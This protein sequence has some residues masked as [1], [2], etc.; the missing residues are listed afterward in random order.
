VS[1]YVAAP[2]AGA[3]KPAADL[4]VAIG[5]VDIPEQQ[6][7]TEF[8]H[9]FP[10]DGNFAVFGASGFGKSTVLMNMALALAAKNTPEDVHFYALD[11]GNSALVQLK[12]LPHTGDYMTYDQEEK[13]GKFS[14]LMLDELSERKRLF[15]KESAIN[16]KMYNEVA[17]EKLPAVFIVVDGFDIVKEIPGELEDFFTRLTR[18]GV[19]VGIYT[20]I[21]VTAVT[22]VRY[23]IQ[24]NI[25]NKISL[26]LFEQ[27]DIASIVGRSKYTLPETKG[28]AFVKMADVNVMQCYLPIAFES[29]VAYAR[30][31]GGLIRALSETYPSKY[32]AGIPM[33]PEYVSIDD[34]KR[35]KGAPLMLVPIGL[36]KDEV[37]PQHL[38]LAFDRHL[39]VGR[40]RSGKSNVLKIILAGLQGADVDVFVAD[41]SAQDMQDAATAANAVYSSGQEDVEQLIEALNTFV[42]TRESAYQAQSGGVRQKEFFASLDPGV[43][44]IDDG[45]YFS[46]LTNAGSHEVAETLRRF[47]FVGGSVVTGASPSG[48]RDYSDV[49]NYLKEAMSGVALGDPTEQAFFDMYKYKVKPEISIGFIYSAGDVVRV[50]M[51]QMR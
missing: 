5:L 24:N 12:D 42:G 22:A 36:D 11:L 29:E 17:E 46:S 50:K 43:L 40:A 41:S 35:E 16:F 10:S 13:I 23:A 45:D 3:A 6:A 44:L 4:T 31:I 20:V 51:P 2:A 37:K 1:P 27:S 18:D 14:H 39:V 26:F 15:A 21:S 28:R 19:G 7:Q 30:E 47:A 34:I 49:S 25:K 9:D 48:L 38:N 8:V 33:L 32:V